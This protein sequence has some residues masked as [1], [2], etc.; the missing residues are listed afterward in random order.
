MARNMSPLS[1]YP[2]LVVET[3]GR[4]HY[5]CF[6]SIASLVRTRTVIESEQKRTMVG[7]VALDAGDDN[8][9][10]AAAAASVRVSSDP[11]ESYIHS[12]YRWCRG[13]VRYVLNARR[14]SFDLPA[15]PPGIAASSSTPSSSFSDHRLAGEL[16]RT[17]LRLTPEQSPEMTYF[18]DLA[19]A[20]RG[21]G[22]LPYLCDNPTSSQEMNDIPNATATDDQPVA[23][24]QQCFWLNLYHALLQHALLLLGPPSSS[25]WATFHSQ[26]CYELF[27]TVFSLVEIEHCC[28]RGNLSRPARIYDATIEPFGVSLEARRDDQETRA[29]KASLLA[30]KRVKKK[31]ATVSFPP[32]PPVDD[33]RYAFAVPAADKTM[34]MV[35]STGGG[36][37]A[38]LNFALHDSSAGCLGSG[39]GEQ[40]SDHGPDKD[41]GNEATVEVVEPRT[42]QRFLNERTS[43]ALDRAVRARAETAP[44]PAV[45][46]L[47]RV[48][49]LYV[50]DFVAFVGYGPQEARQGKDYNFTSVSQ[51]PAKSFDRRKECECMIK[52]CL[53][54]VPRHTWRQ[55]SLIL[56]GIG[57]DIGSESKK[58]IEGRNA[59][60]NSSASNS[61]SALTSTLPEIQYLPVLF[62]TT[63]R[64]NTAAF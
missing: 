9:P 12:S 54:Y 10:Q 51:I 40:D 47:P 36:V 32:V 39:G 44:N 59:P 15:Q 53:R 11:R 18:L 30:R 37:D 46:L 2:C 55:L 34:P 58:Q 41:S 45:V 27:G 1:G 64:L 52:F 50:S 17:A 16:L 61:A 42:L 62:S 23:A 3:A 14:F 6:A 63:E 5:L 33:E 4:C 24:I 56:G 43:A 38:R 28:L 35:E 29:S 49:E 22:K 13:P 25:Q 26:V 7:S 57:S 8:S 21:L 31:R 60:R 48:F 20:L 19:S